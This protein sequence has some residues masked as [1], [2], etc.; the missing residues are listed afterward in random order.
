M[1]TTSDPRPTA[2]PG[3]LPLHVPAGAVEVDVIV[4]VYNEEVDLPRNVRRLERHLR[5][6]YPADGPGFAIT[7][8]D[9]ASTDATLERAMALADEL[10]SVRVMHLE[11][12]GRGLA[13]RTAWLASEAAIL[14]YMDVDLSTDLA[15]FEPLLAPLRSGHSDVAIGSR[16]ACGSHTVRGPKREVISRCY[17]LLLKGSLG[18]GFSDAQCGFKAIRADVARRLLPLVKDDAWFFDTELLVLAEQAGLRVAEVPVDW[19]DDPGSTVHIASTVRED[20]KGIARLAG[21]LLSGRIPLAAV[22]EEL[23]R[24]VAPAEPRG[25]WAHLVRFGAIGVASTLAYLLLFVVLRPM[26]GAQGANLVALLITAVANT[27]ANRALTFGVRGRAGL[28]TH[29]LQGLIVFALGWALTA[30]ALAWVH[31]A[32]APRIVELLAVVGANL[33][34]TVLKFLLFRHWVFADRPRPSTPLALAT[35][36]ARASASE[37]QESR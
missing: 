19:V 20:V 9:N 18:T 22:R 26:A 3:R 21:G 5:S 4:P 10:E 13:L 25:L 34:A 1:N 33:A 15:A 24:D 35:P 16:L 27:A 31:A 28:V 17:N 12:K 7:I 29:H 14:A 36:S 30:S 6:L 11:R 32:Q 8:V 23:G 37:L 2:P